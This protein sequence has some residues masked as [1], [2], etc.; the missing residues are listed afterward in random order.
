[1]DVVTRL[2]LVLA[3]VVAGIVV[4]GT[5]AFFISTRPA[6]YTTPETPASAFGWAYQDVSLR[7]EDG[8]RLAAWLIPRRSG[9]QARAAVVVLHGYPFSK[10]NVLGMTSFLREEYDL[11]L[12]DFRYFGDSE[13]S[14]TTLGLRE[15]RDVVA[16][17]AFLRARGYESVGVWGFSMG[18]AVALLALQHESR[19]DAVVADS[20]YSDLWEMTLDYYARLPVLAGALTLVTDLQSRIFFGAGLADVSPARTA[21]AR[22]TPILLIH[23][24]ADRTIPVA[25]HDRL[26]GALAENPHLE[27]WIIDGV[28]HG[29]TYSFAR[30]AYEARVLS[31]FAEYLH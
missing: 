20:P 2:A 19:A 3:F 14:V 29:Y 18:G 26:R 25:H 9:E 28:D 27:T 5:V 17:V 11:L 24:R 22:Q 10:A 4:V 30:Y 8:V 12:V 21:A 6:R 1:V 13:G 31:F 23:G 7:T 15:W 16:A